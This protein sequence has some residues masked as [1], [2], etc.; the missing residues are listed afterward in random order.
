MIDSRRLRV[1]LE[2]SRS[3]TIAAA[4]D[5]LGY[6]P[7]AV[8]QQL[9]ALEREVGAPLTERRGRGVALTEPGRAL[10]AHAAHVVDALGMAEAEVRAIAGLRAGSLRLGWFTTAGATLMPR[11][12]ARFRERQPA[13]DLALSEGD[14]D[15]C[16][17]ALRATNR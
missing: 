12:I 10:A 5:A 4:A 15:Y 3:G 8:S 7:S 17:A 1:L 9:R 6:T 13:V 14:P 16:A 11:A 2:V